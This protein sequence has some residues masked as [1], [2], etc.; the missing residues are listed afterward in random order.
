MSLM[1]GHVD[2]DRRRQ[3]SPSVNTRAILSHW[4]TIWLAGCD[5]R[6]SVMASH[7]PDVYGS[8]DRE[9]HSR[10]SGCKRFPTYACQ[11]SPHPISCDGGRATGWL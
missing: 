7:R 11:S 4:L 10:A 8:K 3:W 2:D 5:D 1:T 6:V 9:D